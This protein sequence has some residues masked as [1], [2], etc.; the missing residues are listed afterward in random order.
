MLMNVMY[1]RERSSARRDL[2]RKDRCYIT[3][4]VLSMTHY[5]SRLAASWGNHQTNYQL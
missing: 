2:S 4:S 1:A 5:R 3:S